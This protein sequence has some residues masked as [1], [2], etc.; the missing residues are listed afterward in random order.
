MNQIV[1]PSERRFGW[2]AFGDFDSLVN[3][4]F[5]SP[6]ANNNGNSGNRSIAPA[7]DV[8][9]TDN[10][11]TVRAE[12]PGVRKEDLDVTINDGV[13]TINAET[14][15]EHDDKKEGRVI[16]QERRYGKFVR[17]MRLGGDVDDSNVSADYRDG[18]LTLKL[19]KSE[20]VKPKKIDVKVS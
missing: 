4:M 13:L 18:I 6:L 17:S 7:I 1:K 12:L 15:Y 11:Y 3:Q 9:E 19:P 10:G 16:R 20:E 8:S 5:R 14:R 2:D